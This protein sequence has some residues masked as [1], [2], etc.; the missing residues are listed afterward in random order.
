MV[1]TRSGSRL[2]ECCPL[3]SGGTGS[4]IAVDKVSVIYIWGKPKLTKRRGTRRGRAARE[5]IRKGREGGRR[6][7]VGEIRSRKAG[8]GHDMVTRL[9][10]ADISR[11]LNNPGGFT[12]TMLAP[13]PER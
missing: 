7:G 4:R 11:I 5:A 3:P 1:W 9:G 12:Y 13:G 10:H 8:I 2:A 6:N